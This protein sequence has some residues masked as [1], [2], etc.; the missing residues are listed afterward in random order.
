MPR[1]HNLTCTTVRHDGPGRDA[2]HLAPMLSACMTAMFLTGCVTGLA[3]DGSG[4]A[5]PEVAVATRVVPA[6]QVVYP[7]T[8][9]APR[10]PSGW[11]RPSGTR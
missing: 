10:L 8:A 9:T 11:P 2:R 4:P 5:R 6:A 3:G 1:F 7:I